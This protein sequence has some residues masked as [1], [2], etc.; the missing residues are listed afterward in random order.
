M[1]RIRA[2]RAS[3]GDWQEEGG[4]RRGKRDQRR[5]GRLASTERVR[6]GETRARHA[7]PAPRRRATCPKAPVQAPAVR[8]EFA[9]DAPADCTA[10]VG[11]TCPA[12][13][14]PVRRVSVMHASTERVRAVKRA[15]GTPVRVAPMGPLPEGAVQAPEVRRGNTCNDTEGCNAPVGSPAPATRMPAQQCRNYQCPPWRAH[16]GETGGREAGGEEEHITRTT[17]PA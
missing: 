3:D 10:P 17:P 6:A 1:Q 13:Q 16:G 15:H 11:K 7:Q 4:G 5:L 14:V 8:R 2:P 9:D 12:T